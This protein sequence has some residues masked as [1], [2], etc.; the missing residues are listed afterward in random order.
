M[1]IKLLFFGLCFL[2]ISCEDND[3]TVNEDGIINN[4]NITNIHGATFPWTGTAAGRLKRW[5]IENDGLI[6]VKV[7]NNALAIRAMDKIEEVMG[8]SVFDR[9]SIAQ[10]P[11]DEI[12]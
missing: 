7:N 9:T 3:A 4:M 6:A 8:F 11:N 2:L 10:V 1:K 12:A 5:D